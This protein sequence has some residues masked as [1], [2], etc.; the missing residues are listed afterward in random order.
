MT[1]IVLVHPGDQRAVYSDL[2]TEFT[3]IEPPA[4]TRMI[5]GWLISKGV[6]VKVI[7]QEAEG[8]SCEQVAARVRDL[9]PRL[10]AVV[11]VGHQPSASTQQMQAAR[12]VCSTLDGTTVLLGHHVSALPDRTLIEEEIDYACDGEGPITLLGL[13]EGAAPE[14][15][16]GLVWWYGK[17]KPVVR[18]NALATLIPI[19]ELH[20]DVWDL[21]PMKQY[22]SHNWQAF[23]D[24]K[25]RSPYASVYTT[26][27]C[28]W[29]CSFCMINVFQHKNL[30]RRR[31]PTKVVQQ[32][33]RLRE[34]YGVCTLKIADE[35]FVLT[36]GHYEPICDGLIQSGYADELNIWAYARVDTVKDEFLAKLRAAGV[37]WLALGIESASKHVRDGVEKGRFGQEEIIKVVRKIQAAGIYVIGNYIFG[38]PDDTP[39]TMEDTLRLALEANC[40][41]A[42]FYSA[43]AYPG[44][45]LYTMA[46]EKGWEL[47]RSW[48]GYSQHSYET[49]PLRT[50]ACGAAEVLAFRDMAFG[51]YF[52]DPN[53]L[54]MV[55]YKF[56]ADVVEHL[57]RMVAQPLPRALLAPGVDAGKSLGR[58]AA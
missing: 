11:A 54:S 3:A 29:K 19:D 4:W 17:N 26:L 58:S 1:D 46:Q 6:R 16:P 42:N 41:F 55:D 7:D 15:I 33:I 13:L 49:Q 27:G 36:P 38:L 51:R 45:K 2:Y 14:N 34:E 9:A 20:G 28:P 39:E 30:Y 31:D 53:Y 21:L 8:L 43:M 35:M 52:S 56:G 48:I 44:S 18:K 24:L 32:I 57:K 5:A 25:L 50:E 22:R 40:E 47:P 23:T 12:N 37:R 10:T